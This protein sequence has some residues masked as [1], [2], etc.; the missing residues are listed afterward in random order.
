MQLIKDH[1]AIMGKKN[2]YKEFMMLHN[3]LMKMDA[4][5]GTPKLMSSWQAMHIDELERIRMAALRKVNQ[6][7]MVPKRKY[8]QT[9]APWL[10]RRRQRRRRFVTNKRKTTAHKMFLADEYYEQDDRSN[11]ISML[12]FL[13][14][15]LEKGKKY[16]G[17][18][19]GY[20]G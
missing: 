8:G 19:A 16:D 7:A 10:N 1:E 12:D 6:L 15:I 5:N 4:F 11:S 20:S 17:S 14:P 2:V 18:I 13:R 3:K 9:E